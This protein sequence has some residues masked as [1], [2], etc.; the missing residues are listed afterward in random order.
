M[1]NPLVKIT[2]ATLLLALSSSV[3]AQ[4][5]KTIEQC[6]QQFNTN[7]ELSRCLDGV[8]ERVDRELQTWVNNQAFMLEAL[9]LKA[10]RQS[11]LTMFK[12]SQSDFKKYQKDNCRWQYLAISPDPKASIVYKTC[13][14]TLANERI[15]ELQR[16]QAVLPKQ[17]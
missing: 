3:F 12:R 8:I 9:A 14:V 6:Q 11:A 1:I 5:A 17:Q 2:Q 4:Q 15:E 13:Y 10:G 16:S 7:N